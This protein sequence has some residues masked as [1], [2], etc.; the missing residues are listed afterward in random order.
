MGIFLSQAEAESQFHQI[1]KSQN[2]NQIRRPGRVKNL[3][4]GLLNTSSTKYPLE[5]VFYSKLI[6]DN[7]LSPN[8]KTVAVVFSGAD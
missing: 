2:F 3:F 4:N 6:G 5:N 8:I 7:I 1:F